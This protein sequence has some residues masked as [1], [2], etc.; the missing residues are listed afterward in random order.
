MDSV[1]KTE[2]VRGMVEGYSKTVEEIGKGFFEDEFLF[3][4]V[5]SQ[6]YKSYEGKAWV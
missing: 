4:S 3:K 1:N 5:F 6:G 2:A